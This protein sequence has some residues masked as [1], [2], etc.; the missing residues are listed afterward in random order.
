[1]KKVSDALKSLELLI[2]FSIYL[3][4]V[5]QAIYQWVFALTYIVTIS[6]HSSAIRSSIVGNLDQSNIE[7]WSDCLDKR[8]VWNQKRPP[9]FEAIHYFVYPI[10]DPIVNI[11]ISSIQSGSTVYQVIYKKRK[12]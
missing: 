3:D 2:H 1:M 5:G 4:P 9:W 10:L 8:Q 6:G 7:G 12:C 11:M